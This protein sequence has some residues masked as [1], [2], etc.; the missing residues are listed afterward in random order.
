M[1]EVRALIEKMRPTPRAQTIRNVLR[2]HGDAA[3]EPQRN[4][5]NPMESRNRARSAVRSDRAG[6]RST[7]VHRVH[8]TE[9]P[10]ATRATTVT[11]PISTC[12]GHIL[13]DGYATVTQ[14]PLPAGP[15][16]ISC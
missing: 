11:R 5:A 16:K 7:L 2:Y 10:T 8:A 4:G 15:L 3:D 13:R 1:D 12:S 9:V 14:R 6:T